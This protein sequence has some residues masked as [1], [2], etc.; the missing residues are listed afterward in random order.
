MAAT[1]TPPQTQRTDM[2]SRLLSRPVVLNWYFIAYAVIVVVAIAT[3]FA[4]LGD[5][6]MSHDESLHTYY[7]Y[8][9]SLNGDFQ[10][11]PLM[12]GPILFHVTALM[13]SLFGAND[14]TS[15]LYPA[16]LGVLMVLFPLLFRRWLGRT[17]ALIASILILIS[18]LLLFHHR[19]IR[20][21]TPSIFATMVMVWCTFQY[22]DGAIGVRR[23]ARWLYIFAA[24]LLWSLG[25]KEVAFMY[26]AIFG[27]FLTV[28]CG[29][30]LY[31][32]IRKRP[33]RTRCSAASWR[34]SFMP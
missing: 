24:A 1:Y 5:R 33:S 6:T 16:I 32:H 18:P 26:I 9:L 2:I 25:S 8:L 12:H 17:G 29:V 15:R 10:H 31:Q 23:K 14:F 30:R 28:F 4:G 20:E 7:S 13:Y 11:T 21:D 27:L 34:L 3:R 22:V 19:Y